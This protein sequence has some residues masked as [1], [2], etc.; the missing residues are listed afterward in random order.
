MARG[1]PIV[2]EG[3]P[4]HGFQECR[5]IGLADF[6]FQRGSHA[7]QRLDALA[8]EILGVLMQINESWSNDQ[9]FGRNYALA[10]KSIGR[11]FL[12][13]ALHDADIANSIKTCFGI[14]YAAAL[15]YNFV[16]L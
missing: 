16:A 11:N 13:L 14:D 5:D 1:S 7:I 4:F 2:D 6:H 9:P 15:N 3:A 12:D 10:C 8:F